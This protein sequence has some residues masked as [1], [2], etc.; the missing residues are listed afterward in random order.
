MCDKEHTQREEITEEM[1]SNYLTMLTWLFGTTVVTTIVIAL[2]L[3]ILYLMTHQ[4][5]MGW[6]VV[7]VSFAGAVG[8]PALSFARER[9]T[10]GVQRLR[11][12]P[13]AWRAHA[14]EPIPVIPVPN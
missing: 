13:A 12:F 14:A 11:S 3:A 7:Y 1:L 2:S 6:V 9:C 4:Q 10:A 8:S 5:S